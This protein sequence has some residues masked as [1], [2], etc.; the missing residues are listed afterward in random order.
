MRDCDLVGS[1]DGRTV[2]VTKLTNRKQGIWTE[3]WQ[4]VCPSSSWWQ[5]WMQLDVCCVAGVQSGSVGKVHLYRM[6]A[7]GIG[8]FVETRCGTGQ[9]MM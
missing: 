9:E 4:N 7:V 2:G 5:S 3:A 8:S 1:E 6:I